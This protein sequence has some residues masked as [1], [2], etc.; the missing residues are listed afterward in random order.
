MFSNL[1][2]DGQNVQRLSLVLML[3]AFSSYVFSD[4]LAL[5]EFDSSFDDADSEYQFDIPL[6]LTASRLRQSQLDSPASVTVIEADTISAL[7]FKNIEEIFR[8]VPGMLVGYHSGFGEKWPSVSYHGTQ[9]AEHRRLQVLIDGRS[10]FKPGLAR[11]EWNDIPLAIEDISRIEVIRGPNSATYGANSYLGVINILTKHPQ[12]DQGTK[13]KVT[14]GNRNVWDTYINL[15]RRISNTDYRWTIGSKEKSGFD[16]LTAEGDEENRDGTSAVYTNLRT[17]TQFS[18][19]FTFEFQGGYQSGSNEQI[20]QLDDTLIYLSDEDI[21]AKDT[22]A[23]LKLNKEFS[24]EQFSHVQVYT[25]QFKRIQEWSACI[26]GTLTCG[27]FD[28]NLNEV[29]SEI[30]FQHTSIWNENFRTVMGA[31]FRLDEFESITYNGGNTDN[32]NISVFTNAEYK[33]GDAY[34]FNIGGMY[35]D[36]DL[37]DTNFSPRIAL[38]SHLTSNDTIRIIYSEAVR[39]PDL[40]EQN[41]QLLFAVNNAVDNGVYIGNKVFDIYGPGHGQLGNEKIYSHEL[42]YFGL[43]PRINAQV[44]IKIFYD[45]LSGLISESLNHSEPLTNDN[46]LIQKGVEGQVKWHPS[47]DDELIFSFAYTDSDNEFSTNNFA[48]YKESSLSADRSGS[49]I[50][51][52]VL[53]KKTQ[54]ASAYYHVENWNK[55]R[56]GSSSGFTFSRID[57]SVSHQLALSDDYNLRMQANV[58]YRLDDDPLLYQRNNYSS[59]T[60]YYASMIMSY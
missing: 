6:V 40:F 27:L 5:S 22:Y 28:K 50:W 25:Q 3:S 13:L 31:R 36:D 21:D 26:I 19:T 45:E 1:F 47:E 38:N 18:P 37:N 12:E 41:G 56:A 43:Y 57:L 60:H 8:L 49:V 54:L 44:D 52:S 39:S 30:E 51:V 29:K 11:V 59:K 42:S 24:V 34:T 46:R 33:L 10:V 53:S 9:T 58:Q 32:E 17:F 35:E 23:W 48:S 15:S 2:F 4:D 55:E 16:T 7:G 20:E 14:S